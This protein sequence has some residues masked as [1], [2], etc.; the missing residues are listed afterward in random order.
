MLKQVFLAHF[1]PK[2]MRFGLWKIPKCLENGLLWNQKWVKNGS[3]ACF[4]KSDTG[5][6][7][8]LNQMFLAHVEP[9]LTQFSPFR[10]KLYPLRAP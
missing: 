7:G 6:I 9:N 5:Q 4:S 10:T 3:K 8:M 2:V 1:E